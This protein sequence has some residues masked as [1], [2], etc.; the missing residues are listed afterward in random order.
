MML[1]NLLSKIERY[2]SPNTNPGLS[3]FKLALK[4]FR[5]LLAYVVKTI[6]EIVSKQGSLNTLMLSKG[7]KAGLECVVI[8]NG[9]SAAKLN[10]SEV[11]MRVHNN[12]LDVI[13]INNY[14]D[15]DISKKISPNYLLL[16][17]P[18][19]SPENNFSLFTTILD[20]VFQH[21]NCHL[22]IPR[23][24]IKR[25]ERNIPLNKIIAFQDKGFEGWTRNI[26]PTKA[27]GYMSLTAFKAIAL[28][29]YLGY[30]KIHLIGLDLSLFRSISVS[31]DLK[32]IQGL[33]YLE[34]TGPGE[35]FDYT[36]MYP[37]GLADYFYDVSKQHYELKKY[38]GKLPIINLDRESLIICFTKAKANH[39]LILR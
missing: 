27:R 35:S 16:S 3:V 34:G 29:N 23:S 17:D 22:V 1:N 6:Q 32:L 21:P 4:K 9:P 8:A 7:S 24:W 14:L 13:A 10:V 11:V 5:T 38:F 26:K 31:D 20:Q 15:S 12:E 2:T 33:N 30:E 28:A 19:H 25:S 18:F 36:E 39:P 37:G